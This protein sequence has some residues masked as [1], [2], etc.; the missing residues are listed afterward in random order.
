[1]IYQHPFEQ[2][3]WSECYN[4]GRTVVVHS[5]CL[6]VCVSVTTRSAAYFIFM[7]KTKF[8]RGLYD[9]LKVFIMWL[10][11]KTLHSR[12]LASFAGHRRLPRS[13]AK[14]RWTK[15]TAIWLLFNSKSI[16]SVS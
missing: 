10:S 11:V 7:S 14:F 9:V 3:D 1:V 5:V 6:S 2:S 4:H 12:V 16:Y 8:C 15:E 13:L